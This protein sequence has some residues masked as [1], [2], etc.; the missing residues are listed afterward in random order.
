VIWVCGEIVADDALK[1]SVLDRTIEHGIGLFETLRT[2]NGHA[3]L[4]S[5]HRERML[6]SAREL[7]LAIDPAQFPNVAGITALLQASR[8][9]LEI[10]AGVDHRLRITLSGGPL[11][12]AQTGAQLWM[13]VAPLPPALP[14]SGA[15]ITRSI[16]VLAGDPLARHKTLNYWR[17]RIAYETAKAHGSDEVLCVTPSEI[18]CEC[19]R[20]NLFLVI[21][22]HLFT[23]SADGPLLPG[24]MRQVVLERAK[25]L[26][27]KAV[28][29]A[30]PLELA[31]KADEAFLTSSVR[32][33]APIAV[34]LHHRLTAPGPVTSRLQAAILPWLESGGTIA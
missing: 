14:E 16:E 28:E 12:A 23:P 9:T 21:G 31:P 32:G 17:K 24:I 7:G 33:V 30:L 8:N 34:L 18:L 11:S 27:L 29:A 10:Q 22:R 6:A 19:T 2:W 25:R 1:L 20:S 15:V 3:T 26:G 4:L 5:R 13:T